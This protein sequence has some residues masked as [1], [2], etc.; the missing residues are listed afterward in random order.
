MNRMIFTQYVRQYLAPEL[1]PGDIVILD[2]LSSHKGQEA[3]AL[4]EAR[5]AR[6]LF[7]PPYGPDFNPIEMVFAKALLSLSKGSSICCEKPVSAP[8]TDFG[9]A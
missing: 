6:L 7:L 8:A 4:V 3:A 5:G 9:T 2:N 1:K